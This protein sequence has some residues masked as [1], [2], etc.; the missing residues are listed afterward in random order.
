MAVLATY[1][2]DWVRGTTLPFIVSMKENGIPIALDDIRLSVYAGST[3][4]FRMSLA[5]NPGTNGT[6]GTVQ[7]TSPGIFTFTPTAAQTRSLKVTAAG[8]AGKNKYEVEIRRGALEAV[9]LMGAIA[10]IGGINDDEA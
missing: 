9:Y 7:E 8:A 2:F 1:N 6:P 4:L 10:G 5:S 3:M